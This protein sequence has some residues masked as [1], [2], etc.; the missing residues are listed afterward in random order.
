MKYLVNWHNEELQKAVTE[1]LS[2]KQLQILME[3]HDFFEFPQFESGL[4]PAVSFSG[5]DGT[6]TGYRNSWMRDSAVIATEL[7][8]SGRTQP[9]QKAARGLLAALRS[10]EVFLDD[11]VSEGRAPQEASERPPI[12]FVGQQSVPMMGWANAQNDALGYCLWCVGSLVS[13]KKL[14]LSEAEIKLLRKV[15]RYFQ[16]IKYWRDEDSGHWEETPKL[17]SSSVGT[18]MAGISAVRPF[19]GEAALCDTLLDRG[20]KMLDRTLPDESIGKGTRRNADAALLFLVEPLGIIDGSVAHT[21]ISDIE[22]E[23]SGDYGV[24]RYVG[25]SYWAPDYR[26]HFD[27]VSRGTDFSSNGMA[28]RDAFRRK[29]GEAQWTLSDPLLAVYYAK[30]YKRTKRKADKR[31]ANYRLL[32]SLGQIINRPDRADSWCLPEAYCLEGSSWVPNDN[33]GLLWSHANLLYAVKVF[34]DTFGNDVLRI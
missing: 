9:A 8:R 19:V 34:G 31:E 2:T 24:R 30:L 15:L 26:Q 25:D 33:L 17:E 18:V 16:A 23:L 6:A 28:A 3:S 11:I 20:Q 32:R 4:F 22:H 1:G 7:L 13:E 5:A 10:V 12:R 27:I 14:K 29:G 21:I